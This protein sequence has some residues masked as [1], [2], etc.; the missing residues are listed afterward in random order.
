MLCVCEREKEREIESIYFEFCPVMVVALCRCKQR[1]S[2]I[3]KLLLLSVLLSRTS[4]SSLFH[5]ARKGA[6]SL[7][8]VR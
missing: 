1:Q 5:M 8:W 3:T 6:A 2:S 4:I 7:E